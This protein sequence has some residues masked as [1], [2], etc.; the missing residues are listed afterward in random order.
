[1]SITPTR[2]ITNLELL[3]PS[4]II[5]L[6][7]FQSS[8][9]RLYPLILPKAVKNERIHE[10]TIEGVIEIKK[11]PIVINAGVVFSGNIITLPITSP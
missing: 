4:L 11:R 1:M 8:S 5:D 10:R 3:E 6:I 7:L 2:I 9:N